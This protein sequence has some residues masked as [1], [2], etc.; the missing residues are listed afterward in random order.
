MFPVLRRP[1]IF[2]HMI[3][4]LHCQHA[5]CGFPVQ[6]L[7]FLRRNV[8]SSCL[9][10][11]RS[12]CTQDQEGHR[13]GRQ[14]RGGTRVLQGVCGSLLTASLLLPCLPASSL[15]PNPLPAPRCPSLVS[16]RQPEEWI[17]GEAGPQHSAAQ[18]H[19]NPPDRQERKPGTSPSPADPSSLSDSPLCPFPW[20]L[21]ST[22]ACHMLF[23]VGPLPERVST[24]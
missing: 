17:T 9:R 24:R 18:N 20:G 10:Y 23:S 12:T 1:L 22:P 4:I 7:G 16:T 15:P 6:T 5:L 13:H 14:T 3:L 21:P 2:T 11:Q 8:R 19:P